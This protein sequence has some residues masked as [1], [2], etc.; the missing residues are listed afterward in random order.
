MANLLTVYRGNNDAAARWGWVPRLVGT[1]LALAL[2]T[3]PVIAKRADAQVAARPAEAAPFV[4]I[5]VPPRPPARRS[6][7]ALFAATELRNWDKAYGLAEKAG[8]PVL[9]KIVSWIRFT[10]RGERASFEEIAAFIDAN[11]DWPDQDDM[12]RSAEDALKDDTPTHVVIDWFN[13]FPPLTRNGAMRFASALI[14]T[15]ETARAQ[16]LIRDTWVKRNFDGKTERTFYRRFRRFLRG[17]DHVKR[18]DRLLWEGRSWEAR[19][20]LRR[21]HD[22]DQAVAVAR[23]RLRQYRGGVDWAVRRVPDDMQN[24]PGFI[25]E[26]LRWRRRKGR[27]EEAV[28][29]LKDLPKS[30]PYPHLWWRERSTLARRALRDGKVTLAYRLAK[31]HRQTEGADFADAE[32]LA[33]WIA[34]RFLREPNTA[35]G[36]FTRM[37]NAVNYPVSRSRGAYW[38]G[39]ASEAK[40]DKPAATAWYRRAAAFVTSFYGQVAL[41]HV[42]GSD[43]APQKIPAP[44]KVDEKTAAAF[45]SR[46]VVHAARLI[47]ASRERD[48][49]RAFIIH[50]IDKAKTPAE[51]ALI[52]ALA[53]DVGR[54]DVAVRAA[55]ESLRDGVYLIEA[56]WP[57]GPLP[58]NRR[59]LESSILLSLM[60]QESAFNPEAV[61]WAGARGLMQV[62]PA[63]GRVVARRLGMRFSRE[64]LLMDP[65]YNMTIGTAY[66]RQVLEDF[67]GS[68]V[69]ALAAYNAGPNRARRWLKRNGDFRKGD[70]DVI[71][72]IELIPFD[73]TRDY[74]QRVLENLLVYRAL[75][76]SGRLRPARAEAF[77]S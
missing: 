12:R 63:T 61:S 43:G 10:V 68:Y 38:A 60:R 59:G 77:R 22:H 55:K 25:Y 3:L 53:T 29:L 27:D 21:V 52:S 9:V 39:R 41:R 30:L 70:I 15:G 57:Q 34:L 19:R 69:L 62:M 64:R 7:A 24:D 17:E 46:E 37:F 73:Q 56:G 18:L 48:Q 47:A 16:E 2:L 40:G 1:A 6:L 35:L 66:F 5:P 72:W 45:E 32:W 42:T 8:D 44:P 74:V 54:A 28:E 71:D 31:E 75:S 58:Q 14:A 67:E 76:D 51:H 50:L 20:M 4:T 36:H 65:H 23:M 26:R 11:P 13:R 49:F 33:G